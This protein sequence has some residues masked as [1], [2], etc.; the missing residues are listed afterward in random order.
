MPSPLSLFETG[1]LFLLLLFCVHQARWPMCFQQFSWNCSTTHLLIG[2]L[3]LLMHGSQSEFPVGAEDLNSDLHACTANAF[4][5]WAIS[6]GIPMYSLNENQDWQVAQL[7]TET[8]LV[9]S[10]LCHLY[11]WGFVTPAAKEHW[12]QEDISHG[13]QSSC[14]WITPT[15]INTLTGNSFI[16]VPEPCSSSYKDSQRKV[17][18]Q[19][20]SFNFMLFETI[21][22][23]SSPNKN[24]TEM[25]TNLTKLSWPLC[26]A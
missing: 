12:P 1:P 6:Q 20:R 16:L 19:L 14:C 22:F 15:V 8:R 7:K 24:L 10:S 23:H 11:L 2:A 18:V 5:H 17:Q 9:L 25:T 21:A 4:T 26:S 3:G 13:D